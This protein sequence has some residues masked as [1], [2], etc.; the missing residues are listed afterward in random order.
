MVWCSILAAT[1]MPQQLLALACMNLISAKGSSWFLFASSQLHPFDCQ[2]W[3]QR[4]KV[5]KALYMLLHPSSLCVLLL[6]APVNPLPATPGPEQGG[7]GHYG[8]RLTCYRG[9]QAVFLPGPHFLP[10]RPL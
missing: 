3:Q 5:P 8:H 7:Y 2:G 4:V 10:L 9:P 6:P 1:W